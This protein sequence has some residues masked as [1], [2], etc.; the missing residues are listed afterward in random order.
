MLSKV[1]KSLMD[2]NGVTLTSLAKETKIPKA[3][4]SNWMAGG[5]PNMKQL[6]KVADYFGVT[7]DYIVTGELPADP[8]TALLGSKIEVFSGK[9]EI[10]IN[11]ILDKK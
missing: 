7:L 11:K 3:N 6:K 8:V 4:L 10:I 2:E 9:Y 5:N 1:M